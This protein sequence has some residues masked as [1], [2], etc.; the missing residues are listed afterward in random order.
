[1]FERYDGLMIAADYCGE[2]F[3]VGPDAP[4]YAGP[5]LDSKSISLVKN[6]NQVFRPHNHNSYEYQDL[7]E[8]EYRLFEPE[9]CNM[10]NELFELACATDTHV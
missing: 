2:W 7:K 5:A 8:F 9:V 4:H 10:L 6:L 1:M 3:Y